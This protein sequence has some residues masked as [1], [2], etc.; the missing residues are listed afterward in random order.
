MNSKKKA[1][2]KQSTS[3]TVSVVSNPNIVECFYSPKLFF[4]P[5]PNVKLTLS[6]R[7]LN[8]LKESKTMDLITKIK[9]AN[10]VYF[11]EGMNENNQ[12]V[13]VPDLFFS[14]F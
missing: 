3:K 9:F 8:K 6:S 13:C 10:K 12:L 11:S 5:S 14:C 4:Y 1:N 7:I 2:T